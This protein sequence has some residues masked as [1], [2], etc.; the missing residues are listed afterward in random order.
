MLRYVL[1]SIPM[2]ER[3]TTFQPGWLLAVICG[4]LIYQRRLH[5]QRSN[6]RA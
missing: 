4:N 1:S 5:F 3:E 6:L 2:K